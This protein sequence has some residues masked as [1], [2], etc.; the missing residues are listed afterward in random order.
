MDDLCRTAYGHNT[1]TTVGGCQL[2]YAGQDAVRPDLERGE[3]MEGDR[4]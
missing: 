3:R 1:P 2:I 4:G